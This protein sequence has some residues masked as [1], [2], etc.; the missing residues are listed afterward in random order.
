MR[1]AACAFWFQPTRKGYAMAVINGTIFADSLG[2]TSGD[3]QIN[4]SLGNDTLKGLGGADRLDGGRGIDTAFYGDS[5][6]GVTVNL[7]TGRGFFG[8]AEGDTLISIE[9][10]YGS[11]YWDFIVGDGNRNELHGATGSDSLFGGA[12]DDLLFGEQDGDDLTGGAGADRLIGGDGFDGAFYNDSPVG[13]FVSLLT[14]TA[15]H[16]DAEGDTFDSIER[17]V[18][19]AFAD[20]LWGDDGNNTLGGLNGD[21]FLVGAGGDDQMFGGFGRDRMFGANDGDYLNGGA[22]D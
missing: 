3:D 4:G 15:A 13:V 5:A 19:S 18:G 1:V 7:A 12:G 21:D 11:A 9:N 14:N 8:S 16:G 6:A 22:D 17:V 2:G 10:V 20:N